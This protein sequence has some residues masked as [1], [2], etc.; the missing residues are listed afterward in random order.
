MYAPVSNQTVKLKDIKY[1]VPQSQGV[2][3]D[4]GAFSKANVLINNS[5][6]PHQCWKTVRKRKNNRN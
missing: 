4:C 3:V 5:E 1:I 2:S 6:K